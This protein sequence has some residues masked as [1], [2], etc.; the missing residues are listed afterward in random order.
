MDGQTLH[1]I[2]RRRN[3]FA[4]VLVLCLNDRFLH[5]HDTGANGRGRPRYDRHVAL[6]QL[7]HE[8][9]INLLQFTDVLLLDHFERV[10]DL[11]D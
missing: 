11:L 3:Y 1:L 4:V 8:H 10:D 7:V 2:G 9:R 5:A 6:Q